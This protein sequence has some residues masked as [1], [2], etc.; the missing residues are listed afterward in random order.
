VRLERQFP[1]VHNRYAAAIEA[2]R[3]NFTGFEI[4]N[5][6]DSENPQIL[7]DAQRKQVRRYYNTLTEYV[8]GGPVYK[9]SPEELPDEILQVGR[10]GVE[11]VMKSAQMR[12]GRKK[13]KFIFIR[14]DGDSIP[15]VSI[16]NGNPV[17]INKK[18]GYEKE[19]I[20]LNPF[21][22]AKNA[23]DTILQ[24]KKL[25]DGASYFVIANG[26]HELPYAAADL[27]SLA[28]QVIRLQQK[29]GINTKDNWQRWLT[30]F[31]AYYSNRNQPDTINYIRKSKEKF[32]D[33]VKR[34][35]A[36][37]KKKRK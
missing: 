17:F 32:K 29:Y 5:G 27:E 8:E 22:L 11:N 15:E 30:G 19:F 12:V 7:T 23:I 25:V 26:R 3:E 6:Y 16:R 18:F 20:E 21:N 36:K 37:L 35:N 28:D 1:N 31:H 9:M 13:S 10:K 33:R 24:T 34:E 2:I 4:F 14:F